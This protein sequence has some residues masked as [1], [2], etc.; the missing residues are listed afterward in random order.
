[1]HKTNKKQV[2]MLTLGLCSP[3]HIIIILLLQILFVHMTTALSLFLS[4]DFGPWEPNTN[5][6]FLISDGEGDA[7]ICH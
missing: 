3:Y 7:L 5:I 2:P 1:M 6:T 4:H